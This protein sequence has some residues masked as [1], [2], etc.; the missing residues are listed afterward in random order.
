MWELFLCDHKLDI[1]L[2]VFGY[3]LCEKYDHCGFLGH[4]F[5]DPLVSVASNHILYK[6]ILGQ[7]QSWNNQLHYPTKSRYE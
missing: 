6:R 7:I 1:V 5:E 3:F 2:A 4:V